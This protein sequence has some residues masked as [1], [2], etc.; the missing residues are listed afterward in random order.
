MVLAMFLEQSITGQSFFKS[1]SKLFMAVYTF[2][3]SKTR[4]TLK[5]LSGATKE[6]SLQLFEILQ[7]DRSKMESSE[8]TVDVVKNICSFILL[9]PKEESIKIKIDIYND[10]YDLFVK[11]EEIVVQQEIVHIG[12]VLI[13]IQNHLESTVE[14]VVCKGETNKVVRSKITFYL[15]GRK[16]NNVGSI[17]IIP[18]LFST[19]HKK[20]IKY[21]PWIS[22]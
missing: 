19:K 12:K 1:I 11:D 7:R 2:Y 3:H 14:E 10:Y 4:E 5:E 8:I 21:V 22:K 6:L 20:T 17:S 15:S 16:I 9:S 18:Y 13:F